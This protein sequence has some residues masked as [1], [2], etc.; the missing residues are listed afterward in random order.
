MSFH[1]G[2]IGVMTALWLFGRQRG[3]G[4]W[5][6]TDF[7]APLVPP[8][9]FAGRIGNFINGELWGRPTDAPWGMQVPCEKLGQYCRGLPDGTE[10]S[11]PLHA[12]QLYEAALEG[13]ALFVILWWFSAKP[14]PTMAVS[15]L[16]LLCYG[17][18][19]FLVELVRLPDAHIGYLAFD[20]L[21]MGHVLTLPMILLGV[22]LL[23]Y[24]YR[25][26]RPSESPAS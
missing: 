24:A 8:G 2:L 7:V 6:V 4:L 13:I 26:T 10:W 23:A 15:G 16:F 22:F 18:F 3:M 19:R 14:R 20:W 25:S 1:G 17:L 12:T 9:L 21:T 11:P 5:Q